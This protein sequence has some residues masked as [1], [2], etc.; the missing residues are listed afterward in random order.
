MLT[1][2]ITRAH[3]HTH[4]HT[5]THIHTQY[6]AMHKYGHKPT[7]TQTR[8]QAYARTHTAQ[9]TSLR[10]NTYSTHTQTHP[11]ERTGGEYGVACGLAD[12]AHDTLARR[13]TQPRPPANQLFH[14][15]RDASSSTCSAKRRRGHLVERERESGR[16]RERERIERGHRGRASARERGLTQAK[17]CAVLW[18]SCAKRSTKHS[19]ATHPAVNLHSDDGQ[20][21]RVWT[22][23]PPG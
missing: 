20:V 3:T 5:H 8:K 10:T 19:R 21:M 12:R 11:C 17:R 1:V 9:Q 13:P 7:H 6:T 15:Q 14:K 18:G 23:W 4:T 16:E 2:S 22:C